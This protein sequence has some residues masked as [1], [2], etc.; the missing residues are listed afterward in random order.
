MDHELLKMLAHLR[1]LAKRAG[2]NCDLTQMLQDRTYAKEFLDA[3]MAADSE[4]LVLAALEVQ[5]KMGLITVAPQTAAQTVPAPESSV[6][7]KTGV[8]VNKYKFG[9]R[10]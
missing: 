7:T 9:P 3:A 10:G 5:S 6:P 4:E 2:L 8:D 1:I